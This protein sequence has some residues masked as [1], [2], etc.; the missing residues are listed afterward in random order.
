[1]SGK[2]LSQQTLD[3]AEVD[4]GLVTEVDLGTVKESRKLT[5]EQD[6][7][8]QAKVKEI[9]E[10]QKEGE[11]LAKKFDKPFVKSVKQ[12][13]LETELAA[14]I[15]PTVDSF[16]ESRT[17]ALYDPIAP[18]AKKGVTRQ[19]FVES[20]KSDITTMV[21]NEFLAKQP[22]EKFITSRGFLRANS[23][24]ERLG[25][26]SVEQGIDQSIDTA[27]NVTTKTD[28]DVTTETET[29]K[30]QS[31]RETTKFTSD[32]VGNL[33]V[34]TEGK[35]QAEINEDV[36]KQFDEAIAKDLEAMGPVTTFGQTKNI[37][38]A[39]AA[40]IEKATG[41]PAKVFTDKTKNISKKD[42]TSG[43]L[44]A[45]KQYLDTN[46]Q[47]DFNNLPDAF[48]PGTGKATFIPENVK[49][50][51][52]KKND[53]G[54]FVLDKSKTIKDYKDLLGDMV[55]P[56]YRASEAQTIKGL[57]ALSLRNRV[58]EQA[59]P[60][61][62][63]RKT[64]GVKFSKKPK[65]VAVDSKQGRQQLDDISSAR[66]KQAVNKILDL[67]NLTITAGNRVALQVELLEIIENDPN[68]DL[69]VFEAGVLQNSGAMRKR[70]SN[71]DVYYDLSN[72]EK[73]LGTPVIKD[74][75]QKLDKNGKKMFNLPTLDAISKKF[76]W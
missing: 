28:G 74:G 38:P 54:Q 19:D 35:T 2:G 32:F 45:V 70:S 39:L 52:Y 48:A 44:T 10:L 62:I 31:P 56:V 47:R 75:K 71:G 68:F 18:D 22:L 57:I 3:T 58:F 25:I 13:R 29:R 9:Q 14:D 21:N 72:G 43:A 66:T 30:A 17:K 55:K 34:N 76:G 50:A 59:V 5:P 64:T 7:Q 65:K 20:M 42:A 36:Q 73:I 15:K 33:D 6:Q 63:A 12:Q 49:K 1:M 16:V 69:E 27:S 11:A 37:G 8:A 40:L 24:A 46:A 67:P 60:D 23:L 41:M 53:K 26:K 61:A 4:M 51:L